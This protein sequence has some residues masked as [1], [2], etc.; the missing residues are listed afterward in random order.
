MDNLPQN[1][2]QFDGKEEVK[3]ELPVCE[4]CDQ[5]STKDN[6]VKDINGENICYSCASDILSDKFFPTLE[7]SILEENKKRFEVVQF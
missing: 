2:T 3:L 5:P 4:Y 1:I 6:P 7:S